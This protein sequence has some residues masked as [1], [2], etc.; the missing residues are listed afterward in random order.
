MPL[1][2]LSLTIVVFH[3]DGAE[4][5]RVAL[6][7]G[8]EKYESTAALKNPANDVELMKQSFESAG[9]DTVTTVHDLGRSSM[10][11]ALRDFEDQSVGAEVAVVYY[12]GHAM[13]MNGIN[14]LV[15]VDAVLSSDRDVE[16]ESVAIDR[17]QRSLEGATKLKLFILDA[18]RN[19]PFSQSMTRS[20]GTRAVTRG[21]ARVEPESADTLI[22]FASKAGTTALDGEGNNSPFATA[23]AKYLTEPGLDVRI[24][25]GKV[26]DEVV[27]A[28]SREQEPF[29]YGSLGGAQIFLNIKE[30]N[31]TV[32]G[33]AKQEVS[34]TG[35]SEAAADWQNIRDLADKELL[36]VFIAKHGSDPVY[37]M[38]AE[39]KLAL[40]S[41]AQETTN[42]DPADIAWE[43]LK[44]STDAAALT[45][46]MERYPDSSH[47]AEAE[48][49]IAALEPK[50]SA[51]LSLTGKDT[52]ASRDCYL[53][54][55]EPQSMP[56]FL[57]VNFL[58]IDSARALTSCAQAV[59]ENPDDMMLV[60]MLGRA[61]DA[62]RNYVEARSNYQKA[63]DGGNMYALTN[64]GWFSVYGTDGPVDV[65]KG[66]SMFEQASIAGNSYA[67]ASLGYL[68]REGYGGT[69]QDYN[70]A[71]KWYQL[72]A[73]QGYA[74]AMATMG[75]FYREGLGVTKDLNLSLEWYRK[76]AEAG[77]SNAMSSLG[78]A[79][80]NG[81]GTA[82]D[83]IE[84]KVWYEKA[85]AAG[86]YYS[87][88]VIGWLYD[89]GNGVAQDYVQARTWYEKAANGSNAYAM[90][91]LS[92]LY[93]Y[94][95]GTKADA[96]EAARWAAASVEGGDPAKLQE[97]KTSPNNFTPEFRKEMQ[98]LLKDRG[99][100]SGPID[101]D[102]GIATQN[103]ID[104]LTQKS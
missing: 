85:A 44:D 33:D 47:K 81:L 35:Q 70:E 12:S 55:G 77:D 102:F 27:Q 52:P 18:C 25:L 90:G 86:D 89:V 97:L 82:Q 28:T 14:Y 93:D 32:Q 46:F 64:L 36:D 104:K 61:H 5:K 17:V 95:L 74:N 7:I 54:A 16:D 75:W 6:L 20:I 69:R 37:K 92:R 99:L 22:A 88:A 96:R 84:A 34:P 91:N 38:L 103:A 49:Q 3:A 29:V 50:T 98:S 62:G 72:S 53:L 56:G 19:N 41:E 11:K 63:A 67:Q 26:R 57:G 76:G 73:N 13:E 15:P 30:V 60:N 65:P 39:K 66:L 48:T 31:I 10:V 42:A 1:F 83:Y 8:N 9:F 40:L 45:R 4:A 80:Q 71:V 2:A 79:Y 58:K 101:G 23:L 94:G 59:N 87:M 51:G 24:A 68:Y 78:W 100:Y 21:L 43:A